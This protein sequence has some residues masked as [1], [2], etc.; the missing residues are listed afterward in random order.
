[1]IFH[2]VFAA[3]VL[4]AVVHLGLTRDRGWHCARVVEEWGFGGVLTSVPHIVVPILACGLFVAY[5]RQGGLEPR[6]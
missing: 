2:V 1:M 4:G 6:G 3:S 5:A